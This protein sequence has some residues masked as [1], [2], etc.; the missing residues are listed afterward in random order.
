[1]SNG[2]PLDFV[3]VTTAEEAIKLGLVDDEKEFNEI[4]NM[5]GECQNCGQHVWR[6]GGVLLCFPCTTGESDAS[7]DYELGEPY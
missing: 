1:M 6:Y 5:E 2:G 4:A 3:W 7:N